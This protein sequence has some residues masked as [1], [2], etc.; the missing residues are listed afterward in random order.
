MPVVLEFIYRD[1]NL[2]SSGLI[3]LN[4]SKANSHYNK[5]AKTKKII[6]LDF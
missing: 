4:F 6:I 1:Q 3:N 2:D 5:G